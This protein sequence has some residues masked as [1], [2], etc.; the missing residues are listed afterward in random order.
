MRRREFKFADLGE[1]ITEGELT[2][3]LV[4]EGELVEEDQ[5]VAEIETDKA[6]VEIPSPHA[7]IVEKLHAK[8]GD[9]IKVGQ[10]LITYAEEDR[11]P[12]KV[13]RVQ[14]PSPGA[15]SFKE[16][17]Q[18]VGAHVLA[19]PHV[20]RLARE[21]SVDIEQM[22][23]TGPEGRVTD[24]DL[25]RGKKGERLEIPEEERI[26]AEQFERWGPI[27]RVPLR[28]TRR[29]IALR[30]AQTMRMTAPATFIEEA[31]VASLMDLWVKQK[32]EAKK[33]KIKLTL[34]PFIMRAVVCSLKRYPS[35]NAS[36]IGNE[37]IYKKYYNIGF[38]VDVDESLVVPVIKNVDKRS[39]FDLA[40]ELQDLSEK[41]RK[42]KATLSDL[43]GSSFSITN[44]GS[45]GGRYFMPI[46]NYPDVAILGIGRVYEKPVVREG[47]VVVRPVMSLNL[48]F[49]HRMMDG[50][51][52]ARFV[53]DIIEQFKNP[54]TLIS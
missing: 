7:G 34:L 40:C 41:T 54:K 27:K 25:E 20:R 52:G 18:R 9:I 13:A 4:A 42:R 45:I 22:I 50:A 11:T 15:V 37:I 26:T 5:V 33:R 3:W 8:E 29:K 28:G 51:T 31:D 10:T 44:I 43:K 14:R 12:K 16:V 1:G 47:Q 38:A 6:I 49:D 2:R 32:G 19:T 46:I 36:I 30:V 24:E 17:H 48:T 23:G 21:S 39:I 53:N 35:L